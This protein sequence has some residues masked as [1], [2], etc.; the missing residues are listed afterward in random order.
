MV[1][2]IPQ[3]TPRVDLMA[4]YQDEE[5][6]KSKERHARRLI[7][8]AMKML[9][10]ANSLRGEMA[11]MVLPD[12]T[13]PLAAELAAF[14]MVRNDPVDQPGATAALLKMIEGAIDGLHQL[15]WTME[16]A[17]LAAGGGEVFGVPEWVDPNPPIDE[18]PIV[19]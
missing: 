14:Q 8:N 4:K 11:A 5:K 1:D 19:R 12:G 7:G 15:L 18:P 13:T 2:A 10:N 16:G 3:E 17:S 6:Y 9:L